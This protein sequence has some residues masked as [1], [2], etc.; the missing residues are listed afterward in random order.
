M[1]KRTHLGV[2]RTGI[3]TS[4][5]DAKQMQEGIKPF[6]GDADPELRGDGEVRRDYIE[7]SDNLGSVPVP[8]SVKGLVKSGVDMLSGKR[9]QVL[10]DKLG[11]RLAFERGGTRLY[12]TL[13]I[14]CASSSDTLSANDLTALQTFRDQEA[15]HFEIV[16]E[17]LETL[18]A[19][20]TAQTPSADLV[21]VQSMGLVQAMN[22][23]RTTLI[24][25]LQV[26]LDAEL[27]DNAGWEMLIELMLA[28]GHDKLARSFDVAAKQEAQHL[29]HLRALV[30]RLTL[31]D[32]DVSEE[33]EELTET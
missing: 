22:D 4:P 6:L 2:N 5:L 21:G 24:Q 7:E 17:A 27:I 29:E 28:N 26:M 30:S 1:E 11:E 12:D 20:P 31:L 32:A 19:D 3:Q 18:G 8:G 9:P 25:S 33:A 10:V 16:A 14:K 13:L 23:P 15:E